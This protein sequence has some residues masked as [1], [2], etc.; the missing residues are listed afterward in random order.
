[1]KCFEIKI[2]PGFT[3]MMEEFDD[4]Y[5]HS[6]IPLRFRVVFVLSNILNKCISKIDK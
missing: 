5:L 3:T 6:K 4:I 2:A 1:M